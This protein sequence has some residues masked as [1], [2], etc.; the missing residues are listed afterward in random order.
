[1]HWLIR[2]AIG[3]GA[4]LLLHSVAIPLVY[5]IGK[6]DCPIRHTQEM[7]KS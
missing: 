2:P 6:K 1:M 3:W 4:W 5:A 7:N